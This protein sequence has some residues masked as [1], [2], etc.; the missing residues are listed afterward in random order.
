M[1]FAHIYNGHVYHTMY[2]R[3]ETI[4]LESFQN[5]GNNILALAIAIGNSNEL[6]DTEVSSIT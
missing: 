5:T 2:D 1:D 3:Y 6:G 4:P